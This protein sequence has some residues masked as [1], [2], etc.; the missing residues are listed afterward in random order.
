LSF[1]LAANMRAG[2]VIL[3]ILISSI[4]LILLTT[5]LSLTT[6][7]PF[8]IANSYAIFELIICLVQAFVFTLLATI[9]TSDYVPH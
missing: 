9:Y 7:I 1:R 2:H 3:G 8:L 4:V 6:I 5:L